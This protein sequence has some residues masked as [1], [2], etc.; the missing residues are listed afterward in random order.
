MFESD[1]QQ[2]CVLYKVFEHYTS[3]GHIN[4]SSSGVAEVLPPAGSGATPPS[5]ARCHDG[6]ALDAILMEEVGKAA[7][8]KALTKNAR[9]SLFPNRG[10]WRRIA[11]VAPNFS[12]TKKAWE[13]A[14]D[15]LLE[16]NE[17]VQVALIM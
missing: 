17:G 9:A 14:V 12:F 13:G 3:P 1:D 2:Q 6:E 4:V 5:R 8:C 10:M 11:A 16:K 15:N 7:F